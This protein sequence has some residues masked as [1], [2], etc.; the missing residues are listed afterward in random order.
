MFPSSNTVIAQPINLKQIL[1]SAT[2][3]P[4]G[5]VPEVANN[6]RIALPRFAPSTRN[7]AI[8]RPIRPLAAKAAVRSTTARLD[9]NAMANIAPTSMSSNGSPEIDA[10]MTFTPGACD[11]GR[12]AFMIICNASR[13]SP[14]PM[15]TLPI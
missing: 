3:R 13:I 14:T 7:S 4:L 9:Q 12:A 15:A 11:R 2:L 1:P 6:A 8:F 10:R 5:P